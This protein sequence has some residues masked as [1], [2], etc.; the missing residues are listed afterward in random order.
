[1]SSSYRKKMIKITRLIVNAMSTVIKVGA[2]F[3][4]MASTSK[5]TLATRPRSTEHGFTFLV[6]AVHAT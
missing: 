1:M 2:K 3:L 5:R 6:R 4:D